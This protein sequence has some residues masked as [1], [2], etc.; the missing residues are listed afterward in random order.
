MRNVAG[1]GETSRFIVITGITRGLGRALADFYLAQGHRVAGCGTNESLLEQLQCK[2]GPAENYARVDVTNAQQVENWAQQLIDRNGSPDL[3][4]CNAGMMNQHG[5]VAEI[6]VT[7]WEQM[8]SLNV[9]GVVHTLRSFVPAMKERQRGVITAFTSAAGHRGYPKI[10]PYCATKHAV[11]GILKS[12]SLELPETMASVPVQPGVI[13]TDLLRGHYG[14]R[15]RAQA[16]PERWAAVA[17]PF[18]L[19]LGPTD[20]GQSLRIE[21]Y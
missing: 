9:M 19:N 12:L 4:I 5:D 21:G 1:M 11:E 20:N 15:S 2:H 17:A 13:D 10:A 3:L 14:E 6:P 8:L 18:L 16:S 7:H